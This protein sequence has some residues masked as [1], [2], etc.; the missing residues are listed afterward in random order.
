M[1]LGM[2]LHH[3]FGK[4]KP[5]QP[6]PDQHLAMHGRAC[7]R[8]E[9]VLQSSV[10][11][12]RELL[13]YYPNYNQITFDL[14]NGNWT[15]P[16]HMHG[17][18]PGQGT[19]TETK[20]ETRCRPMPPLRSQS[21]FA[22]QPHWQAR[23]RPGTLLDRAATTMNGLSLADDPTAFVDDGGHSLWNRM[24]RNGSAP[25]L[26]EDN[27]ASAALWTQ[28]LQQHDANLATWRL[29][30]T[31]LSRTETDHTLVPKWLDCI[32]SLTQRYF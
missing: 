28:M 23:N 32:S 15:L 1:A 21:A 18:R 11:R 29:R 12:L 30:Y 22:C 27:P 26:P 24:N 8:R 3:P 13:L 4:P 31:H 10:L 5:G 9:H 20:P 16:V 19:T 2:S 14:K 6:Q 17:A 7:P 25:S